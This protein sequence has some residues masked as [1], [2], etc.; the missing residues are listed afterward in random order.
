MSR[1][2]NKSRSRELIFYEL[3]WSEITEKEKEAIA[4][5]D[6]TEYTFRRTALNSFMKKFFNSH[7]ADPLIYLGEAQKPILASVQQSVCWMTQGDWDAIPASGDETCNLFDPDR[8]RELEKNDFAFVTHSLGS[9]IVIDMAQSIGDWA[10]QQ[11]A[12]EFVKLREVLQDKRLP[13]YMMANQLPLLELGRP[14]QSVR[15]QID[16][17]CK[18][19]GALAGERLIGQMPIYAFSD[20]NDMLSYPIPPKFADDYLD[21]RLCPRITNITL[22]V[23]DPISLFG[24]GEVA[25]PLEAHVGYE[26]DERV[27]AFIAHGIGHQDQ[28]E[29]IEDRCTWLETTDE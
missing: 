29:I 11:T 18:P 14:P 20:P 13:V 4:F 10:M 16:A 3:T 19:D 15:G 9:R 23:A 17:Y 27:I 12:P 22:N 28:S 25:N 8:A 5:D 1:Y 6:A 2:L 24:L 26:N 7:V 21:S